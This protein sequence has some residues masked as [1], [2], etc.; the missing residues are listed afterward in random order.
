MKLVCFYLL[1]SLRAFFLMRPYFIIKGAFCNTFVQ[2]FIISKIYFIDLCLCYFWKIKS[3]FFLRL[4]LCILRFI[5]TIAIKVRIFMLSGQRCKGFAQFLSFSPYLWFFDVN[6]L[7]FFMPVLFHFF[8]HFF[9]LMVG[10][11]FLCSILSRNFLKLS[12]PI[13]FHHLFLFEFS[14]LHFFPILV[15][16]VHFFLEFLINFTSILSFFL[17]KVIKIF[18]D[19]CFSWELACKF[20]HL[21]Y[22]KMKLPAYN[23]LN[24]LITCC[25]SCPVSY[26]VNL[27]STFLREP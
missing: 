5:I 20:W 3:S 7:T 19:F 15:V 14:F 18:L 11:P 22:V 16:L 17:V 23:F 13:L 2:I 27:R 26:S 1:S 12:F 9:C 21:L 8:S 24:C 4:S 6:C 25:R 10:L